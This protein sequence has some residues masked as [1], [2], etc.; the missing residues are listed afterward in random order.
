MP[1]VFD[2]ASPSETPVWVLENLAS[3]Q[4]GPALS[5]ARRFGHSF[6]RIRQAIHLAAAEDEAR[7]NGQRPALVVSSGFGGGMRALSLRARYG[8]RLVHCARAGGSLPAASFGYP[9]DVLVVP[10]EGK[11]SARVLGTLG[12]MSPVSPILIAQARELWLERLA[13]LPKPRV[14]L[15]FG[16]GPLAMGS[17]E[18]EARLSQ[19]VSL[20]RE[21]KGSVL[22][23]V[24]PGADPASVRLLNASLAHCMH[25][26]WRH[27]EPDENPMLGFMGCSDVVVT[28]AVSAQTMLEAAAADMPVF[29]AESEATLLRRPIARCL[30]SSDFV[31]PLAGTF[32]PWCRTPLDEAGRISSEIKRLMPL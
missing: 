21:R 14:T 19:I 29:A 1:R 26:I 16:G 18:I 25:L 24:L 22:A 7:A 28:M 20:V 30:I 17:V 23:C 9:F 5:L 15:L 10:Q 32:S 2:T 4:A 31:R 13:H 8:C 27:G 12:P 3:G 11:Y 6:R